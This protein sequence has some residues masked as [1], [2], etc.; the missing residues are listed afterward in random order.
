MPVRWGPLRMRSRASRMRGTSL[1]FQ[2]AA[3]DLDQRSD[4]V[5]HHVVQESVAG[6]AK[7]EEPV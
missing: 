3:A 2:A 6:D 4:D 7:D 5:A 1:H